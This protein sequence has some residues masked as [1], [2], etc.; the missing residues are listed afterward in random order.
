MV[1]EVSGGQVPGMGRK[2]VDLDGRPGPSSLI[3]KIDVTVPAPRVFERVFRGEPIEPVSRQ[4][5]LFSLSIQR[6]K[7][8]PHPV[9]KS[10]GGCASLRSEVSFVLINLPYYVINCNIFS[11]IFDLRVSAWRVRGSVTDFAGSSL[12]FANSRLYASAPSHFGPYSASHAASA[13]SCLRYT[14]RDITMLNS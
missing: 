2:P 14:A 6:A 4:H 13:A 8:T 12:I 5:L 11:K 3:S 10:T 9:Q 1:I 7:S